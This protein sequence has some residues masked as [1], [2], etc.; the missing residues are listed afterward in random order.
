MALFL[1]TSLIDE[2]IYDS[3]FVVVEADSE[4]AVATQILNH[5]DKWERFLRYAFPR[6]WNN[7]SVDYGSLL[8]CTRDENMTPERFLE[9]ISLTHVDGDSERQLAIHPIK[10]Q[11]LVKVDLS[12]L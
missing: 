3:N 8:G 7:Q 11:E 10:V 9:L 5:P 1:I 2:G 6:E 12:N 4:L